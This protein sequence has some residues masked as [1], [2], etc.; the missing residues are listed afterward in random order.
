MRLS[1]EHVAERFRQL[2]SELAQLKASGSAEDDL[3]HAVEARFQV[4]ASWISNADRHGQRYDL[5]ERQGLTDLS[6]LATIRGGATGMRVS[7]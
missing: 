2:D 3:W 6:G 4:R 5:T 1:R 7:G